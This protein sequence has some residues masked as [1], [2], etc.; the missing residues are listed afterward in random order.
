M[1]DK[2]K[3][4]NHWEEILQVCQSVRHECNS[5]YKYDEGGNDTF[6][7][8]PASEPS[9]DLIGEPLGSIP[10]IPENLFK[11]MIKQF[12]GTWMVSFFDEFWEAP[13]FSHSY[14]YNVVKIKFIINIIAIENKE[15]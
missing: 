1:K 7:H 8:S 9:Q 15:W 13:H 3:D 4:S 6:P 14:S 5:D 11:W 10:S 12:G 2:E